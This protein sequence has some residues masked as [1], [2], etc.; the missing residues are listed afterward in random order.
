MYMN[1]DDIC[2]GR[3]QEVP[4]EDP[5]LTSQYVMEYSY[6]MGYGEDT[7]YLKLV[8]TA[9]HYAD[10]DQ[11]GTFG[12][13]R[14]DFD[15]NVSAQDQGIFFYIDFVEFVIVVPLN[16]NARFFLQS[17]TTG[18]HGGQRFKLGM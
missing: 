15:A 1:E 6:N 2:R 18:Q 10:Y 8:S 13:D 11:E 17:S 16:E 9:K 5:F 7:K 12:V 14:H 4:G 3:G